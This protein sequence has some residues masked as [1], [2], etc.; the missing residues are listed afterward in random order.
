MLPHDL[1]VI[2]FREVHVLGDRKN[3]IANA[4]Q[5]EGVLFAFGPAAS[6]RRCCAALNESDS[7]RPV[8]CVK[9]EGVSNVGSM[10]VSGENHV[11]L[12]VREVT[13]HSLGRS[14]LTTSIPSGGR[15]DVVVDDDD[16]HLFRRALLKDRGTVLK[17]F[18]CESTRQQ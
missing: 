9:I 3:V 13:K 12:Q 14:H 1:E 7:V 15:G 6:P 11:H 4:D 10:F 16:T 18:A 17:L 2:H 8:A 5:V